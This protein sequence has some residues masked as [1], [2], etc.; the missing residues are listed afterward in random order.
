[1]TTRRGL[2]LLLCAMPYVAAC[3]DTPKARAAELQRIAATRKA[4][5]ANRMKA[6]NANEALPVGMWIMPPLLRE[7]SGL[8]LTSRGTVFTHDDNTGRVSEIDPKTGILLKSFSLLGNQ[9]EDFEAITIAGNDLYLMASDGKLFRFREGADGQQ[10]SFQMVDTGLGKQCEFESLAYEADSTRLVMVCKRILDKSAPKD[11]VIYRMPLPLNRA[12]FSVVQVP[13]KQVIGS[14]KWKGFRPSDI[15]IDPFTRNYVIIASHE[16]GLL[17]ITPD[18]DVVRSE[19]LPGDHR[20]PE[21]VAIT[22]D[23]LLLISDEANVKPAAITLYKWR[24]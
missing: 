1:M 20:Q 5:L 3:R 22:K 16:K 6:A 9:K 17:V 23:S 11:L 18:G 8:T 14:N 12:T 2:V 21:G 24:P 13:I 7:I 4:E 15:T 10:V 19:P